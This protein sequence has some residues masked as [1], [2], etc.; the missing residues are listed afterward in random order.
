MVLAVQLVHVAVSA[1]D[2]V[3]RGHLGAGH[4][5]HQ[6]VMLF[7]VVLYCFYGGDCKTP[8]CS[9]FHELGCAHHGAVL[10][11]D[12]AA[13]AA[14]FKTGQT[15]QVHGGLCVAGALQDAVF[16]CHQGEHMARPAEILWF[17]VRIRA[18]PGRGPTLFC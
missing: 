18:E 12:F 11:H 2:P 5:F 7:T 9:Q 15:H 4:G 16:L 13:K 10:L 3:T 17:C 1:E 8:F 14:F 6:T